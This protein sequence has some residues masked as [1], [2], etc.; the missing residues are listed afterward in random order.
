M[1][2]AQVQEEAQRAVL[3]LIVRVEEEILRR[4]LERA[5]QRQE[6]ESDEATDEYGRNAG[7]AR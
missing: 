1:Q 7:E 3:N 6:V 4:E 5:Q 2:Q